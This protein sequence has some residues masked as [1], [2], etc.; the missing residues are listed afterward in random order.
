M[1][2]TSGYPESHPTEREYFGDPYASEDTKSQQSEPGPILSR[3]KFREYLDHTRE[4]EQVESSMMAT[5]AF[6]GEDRGSGI[7]EDYSGL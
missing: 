3:L 7:E 6:L 4:V 5:S 2:M 1:S